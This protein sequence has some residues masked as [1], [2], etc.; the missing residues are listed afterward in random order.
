MFEY[1]GAYDAVDWRL[2]RAWMRL[3]H[4][5][6]NR[7]PSATWLRLRE[8]KRLR[9]EIERGYVKS[10][11]CS[12]SREDP[13]TCSIVREKSNTRVLENTKH[14]LIVVQRLD[15][16]IRSGQLKNV[17][18]R[19]AIEIH[20]LGVLRQARPSRQPVLSHW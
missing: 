16:K 17:G 1:F 12:K 13:D 19:R 2:H 18:E 11:G 20:D 15:L 10:L 3:D 14:G 7:V 4:G 5:I 8:L 6:T 9:I